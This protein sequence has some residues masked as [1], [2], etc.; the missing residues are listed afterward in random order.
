MATRSV[1]P[2][3]R[4][5]QKASM[6][7]SSDSSSASCS[8]FWSSWVSKPS[9]LTLMT[10]APTSRLIVRAAMIMSRTNGSST[11]ISGE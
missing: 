8:A 10:R 11:S 1:N 4:V 7:M 2:G 9:M 6:P 3:A 5:A